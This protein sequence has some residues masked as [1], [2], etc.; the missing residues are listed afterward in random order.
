MKNG[1]CPKCG[2]DKIYSASDLPLKGGPFGSNS[3]PIS[4]TSMAPLD[5]YVCIDCGAVESYVADK[6]KLDEIARKW[7]AVNEDLKPSE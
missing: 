1:R 2:S 3:I 5:N 6:Y 7:S 4:L